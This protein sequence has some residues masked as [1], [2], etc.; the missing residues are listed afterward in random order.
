[1]E[2][3][4]RADYSYLTRL[5]ADEVL[6]DEELNGEEGGPEGMGTVGRG[7]VCLQAPDGVLGNHTI[8][9]RPTVVV[10]LLY[11]WLRRFRATP[12]LA[13]EGI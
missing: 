8:E 11:R 9:C 6:A 13:K 2:H 3:S 5:L 7:L 4:P 10:F 12:S 1:M